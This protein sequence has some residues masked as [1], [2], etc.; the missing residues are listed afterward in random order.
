MR[1]NEM[2]RA[3]A[4]KVATAVPVAI[5]LRVAR[6]ALSQRES[7][8]RPRHGARRRRIQGTLGAVIAGAAPTV[9]LL[10]ARRRTRIRLAPPPTMAGKTLLVLHVLSTVVLEELIWRAP[11]GLPVGPRPRAV[12]TTLSG[13]GFLAVH[14]RRDG[15]AQAGP[16]LINTTGWTLSAFVSHTAV[17]SGAAHAVYNTAALLLR[18]VANGPGR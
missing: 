2:W 7:T 9:I 5:G 18:P 11:L 1:V 16:H 17:W 8:A 6:R 10:A 3:D 15:A 14:V 13:V 4:G 12:L